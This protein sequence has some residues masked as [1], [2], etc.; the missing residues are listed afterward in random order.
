MNKY[1]EVGKCYNT[2]Q[3]EISFKH[4]EDGHRLT[5]E[6]YNM[7]IAHIYDSSEMDEISL[8]N[9][10][11][12][13]YHERNKLS[14]DEIKSE[15]TVCLRVISKIE[16]LKEKEKEKAEKYKAQYE[17]IESR[18]LLPFVVK[19]ITVYDEENKY[20][21]ERELDNDKDYRKDNIVDENYDIAYNIS[22]QYDCI[23]IDTA[24]N[25]F[26]EI[27]EITVIEKLKK[28]IGELD[29]Y[30]AEQ[31]DYFADQYF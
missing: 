6:E 13:L 27:T 20:E 25:N 17:K 28:D 18:Y 8:V 2:E 5:E 9:S 11:D 14:L 26:T 22:Q 3:V 24:K 16:R 30:E 10:I 31:A 12:D 21:P 4:K 7:N 15:L 29:A 23:D 1:L 19:S